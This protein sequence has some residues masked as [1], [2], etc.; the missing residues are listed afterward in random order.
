MSLHFKPTTNIL[1][2]KTVLFFV[3]HSMVYLVHIQW[4]S[5]HVYIMQWCTVIMITIWWFKKL[6]INWQQVYKQHRSSFIVFYHASIYKQS[7]HC[8]DVFDN[9]IKHILTVKAASTVS[10]MMNAQLFKTCRRQYN[11]IKSLMKKV[12]I[13]LVLLTYRI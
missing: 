8:Q 5:V 9:N 10:L 3:S 7:S 11:G 4:Y 13:L 6:G 1:L 12:C 2:H